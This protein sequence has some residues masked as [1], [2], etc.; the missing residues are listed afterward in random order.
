MKALPALIA[1]LALAACGESP[2]ALAER[3]VKA[4]LRDPDSAQFRNLV[5]AGK[6]ICGEVNSRNGYGGYAG[7]AEFIA[8][9]PGGT[10]DI[11]TI[12]PAP[13]LRDSGA[14]EGFSP[15]YGDAV[16]EQQFQKHWTTSC[17]GGS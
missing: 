11:V 6:A 4:E 14:P 3:D 8:P 15:R 12:E 10:A 13:D 7:F 9:N 17:S 2:I 16:L 1:L 5:D